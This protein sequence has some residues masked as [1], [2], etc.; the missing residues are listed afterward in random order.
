MSRRMPPGSG[1]GADTNRVTI[2]DKQG[3]A[4]QLPLLSKRE[5]AEQVLDRVAIVILSL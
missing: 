1:F 5:V 4:D 2:I 3:N